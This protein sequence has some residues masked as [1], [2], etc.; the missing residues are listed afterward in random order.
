MKRILTFIIG[1]AVTV[2]AAAQNWQD[3]RFFSENNYI[4]TARTLGMGNAV[5]AIGGDPGSISINPAGS[6]VASYSQFVISPGF[7][8]STTGAKGV[9]AQ[10]EGSAVGLGDALQTNYGRF[11]LPNVGAIFTVNTGRRS[12]WKR[13]SF[14]FVLNATN[15][16][17]GRFNASGVN[18]DN[19][20]AAS[21]ASSAE[22]YSE[23][24]LG[25][26]SW[27]YDGGDIARMPKWVDMM[28]YRAGMFNGIP[29]DPG[30]YQAVTEVRDAA[31]NF[32][33]A[34]PLYQKYG[35]QSYGNKYDVVFNFSA[36]YEDTFYIGV[37]LGLTSLTYRMSEYFYE[38]PD[39]PDD[40]PVIE[41]TD[42]TRAVF[43]SLQMKHNFTLRGNGVYAK[44][45]FLWRPVAG[46]R[47]GA[48]VQT[49]TVVSYSAR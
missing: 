14:G 16:Y 49:P 6:S 38:A 3:A 32:W 1:T 12:G 17:T 5:T 39:N 36:D 22:G 44:A 30:R 45:G 19:S 34:A 37:N 46:L 8:L 43:N 11:A 9:V 48:A 23:T 13:T 25:S 4:G 40:F 24:V 35:Q 27:W 28:G 29:G 10:G 42:G 26:E 41:Y 31:G 18:A 20:Y 33:L 2:A 7:A 21:L 15:N 47:L